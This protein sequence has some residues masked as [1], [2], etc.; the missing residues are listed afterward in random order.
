MR[1]IPQYMIIFCTFMTC[2]FAQE[3]P[4]SS[5]FPVTPPPPF[6]DPNNPDPSDPSDISFQKSGFLVGQINRIDLQ[7][8]YND[9]VID[10]TLYQ[11]T[12]QTLFSTMKGKKINKSVLIPGQLVGF[13]ANSNNHIVRI[14]PYSF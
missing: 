2:C 5:I 1:Y 12:P 8:D 14:W 13:I 7:G 6:I 11:L 4:V 10:D 9:I 3:A